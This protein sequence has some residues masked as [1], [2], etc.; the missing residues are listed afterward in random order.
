MKKK[1]SIKVLLITL[2]LLLIGNLSACKEEK[3]DI[4]VTIYPIEY[5]TKNIVK[6]KLVVKSVYPLGIDVHEYDP[7]LKTVL[8]MA[9]SKAIIYLGAGLEAFMES[10]V[11]STLKN[12]NLLELS[13][14]LDMIDPS[15]GY[16]ENV[17]KKPHTVDP[18]VWLDP[19]QMVKMAQKIL[20]FVI[21]IKPE[22]REEF[23]NNAQDV[24]EDLLKLDD[25]YK[26]ALANPNISAK[27]MLVDHNAYLYLEYRYGIKIIK[28]RIDNDST[29]VIVPEYINNLQTI[30]DYNIK[31]IVVTA[32]ENRSDAVDR[33][34]RDADLTE[35]TLHHLSSLTISECDKGQDYIS[36]MRNNLETLIRIM[37][38][39]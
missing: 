15:I 4:Y 8:G 19:V 31:Y 39:K 29:E 14:Y 6:D 38:T 9:D 21:E 25:D 33:Y 36:I 17:G 22:Y 5:L 18:H 1:Y 24:I 37:P 10:A 28:T 7:P 20:E 13:E 26:K 11:T 12:N 30:K 35:V 16:I 34:I 2:L 32:H 23:E 27:M 3:A